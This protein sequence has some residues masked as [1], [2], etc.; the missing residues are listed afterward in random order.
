MV[1]VRDIGVLMHKATAGGRPSVPP[2]VLRLWSLEEA[3]LYAGPQADDS[4]VA[5][6]AALSVGDEDVHVG[7]AEHALA[8]YTCC[9]CLCGWHTDCDKLIG[10][11][12]GLCGRFTDH[13]VGTRFVC[14]LCLAAQQ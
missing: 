6:K 7:G 2:W 1:I 3:Q 9:E 14:G 8:V 11:P 10:K 5:C 13:S 12:Q 4:C